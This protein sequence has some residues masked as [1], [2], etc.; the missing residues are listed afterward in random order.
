MSNLPSPLVVAEDILVCKE[1]FC[2]DKERFV[3]WIRGW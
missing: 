3:K 2:L 1:D